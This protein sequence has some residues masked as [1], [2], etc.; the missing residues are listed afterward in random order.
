MRPSA[1][2]LRASWGP[3]LVLVPVGALVFLWAAHYPPATTV[4]LPMGRDG[5]I[6]A[7]IGSQVLHGQVPLR[8]I[9][10]P[11]PPGVFYLDAAAFLIGG[12]R[13]SSVLWLELVWGMLIVAAAAW[14]FRMLARPW[15]AIAATLLLV[16]VYRQPQLLVGGNMTEEYALLPMLLALGCS[17]RAV[18]PRSQHRMLWAAGAGGA[19]AAAALFNGLGATPI[20]G[21]FAGLSALP[22]APG[23]SRF[24]A[25]GAGLVA[26]A[27]PLVSVL[28]AYFLI[29]GLPQ[30]IDVEFTYL[31][32]YSPGVLGPALVAVSVGAVGLALALGPRLST[33]QGLGL[34]AVPLLATMSADLIAF[35]TRGHLRPHYAL[36]LLPAAIALLAWALER[37]ISDGASRRPVRARVTALV[38]ALLALAFAGLQL[39]AQ[40]PP[41]LERIVALVSGTPI[42]T[43]PIIAAIENRCGPAESVYVWGWEPAIN[44][45]SARRSASRYPDTIPLQLPGY[46]NQRRVGELVSD[47]ARNQPCLVIDTSA[48]NPGAPPLNA[49]NRVGWTP[50]LADPGSYASFDDVYRFIDANYR[51]VGRVDGFV[52]YGPTGR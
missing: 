30:L 24:R 8:D 12:S 48:L 3:I 45:L 22:R 4:T 27:L 16:L 19:A 38:L 20:V 33:P 6:F 37:W 2:P 21:L 23:S 46:D 29:D 17:L 40:D 26:F 44:F 50:L 1:W 42:A 9:W 36:L 13:E 35:A 11:K 10:E 15:V 52:L 28:L 31:R 39:G 25:M 41:D 7:Y 51:L 47:L 43:P 5:G 14:T 18:A 49:A 32:V 34:A